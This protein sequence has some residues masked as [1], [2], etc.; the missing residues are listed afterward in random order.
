MPRRSQHGVRKLLRELSVSNVS[1]WDVLSKLWIDNLHVVPCRSC[2]STVSSWEVLSD[3]GI[4]EL[5]GMPR[6]S[7]VYPGLYQV[8]PDAVLHER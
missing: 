5:H 1:C 8:R 3:F 7:C 2:V 6:R 4:D